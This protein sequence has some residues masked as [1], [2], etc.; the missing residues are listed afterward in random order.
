MAVQIAAS[1]SIPTVSELPLIGSLFALRKDSLAFIQRVVH[2]CG[3]AGRFHLGPITGIVFN[4][5]ETVHGVLVEQVDAFDKGSLTL[6]AYHT[7]H[8]NPVLI[9]EGAAHQRQRELL[10]PV[11]TAE[12]LAR[13]ADTMAV[14]A[15]RAQSGWQDGATIDIQRALLALTLPLMGKVL[16]DI[17]GLNGD[18][19]LAASLTALPDYLANAVKSPLLLPLWA[20]TPANIR[21]RHAVGLI[22]RQLQALIDDRRGRG[23]QGFDDLLAMLLAAQAAS[24]VGLNDAQ[25]RDDVLEI[26]NAGREN[27]AVAL[28]WC[29]YLLATHPEAAARLRDEVDGALHDRSPAYADLPRLPYTL[30]VIKE[31]LR[32]YPPVYLVLPRRALRNVA[33]DGYPVRKGELVLISPYTMHH[34]ADY[35]PD[36]DRFNPDRFTAE[37]EASLPP[38]AFMPFNAGP[39]NCLGSHFALMEAQVILAAMLQRVE[40]SLVPGQRV[41]PKPALVLRQEDGCKVIVRR[42]ARLPP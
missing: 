15:E 28:A 13:Y 22:K 31:A 8:S 32:L 1:K 16:F 12:H 29:V 9:E 37:R 41:V 25:V 33:I 4:S 3:E 30:Q 18:D 24:G 2:E 26:F 21:I 17:D 5:S 40:F 42:R 39:H 34:R 20:P 35:F 11:F 6:R 36:P 7:V 23:L 38:H 19:A 10:D 14:C 27:V